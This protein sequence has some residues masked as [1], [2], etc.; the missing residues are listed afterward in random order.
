MRYSARMIGRKLGKSTKEVY[1]ILKDMGYLDGNPGNWS[2]TELGKESG[3]AES[4]KD[5]HEHGRYNVTY[6]VISWAEN[7]VDLLKKK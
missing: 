4:I 5:N 3:G 2:L 7:I 6:S 1:S